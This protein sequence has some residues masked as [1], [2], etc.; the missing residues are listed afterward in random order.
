MRCRSVNHR[1]GPGAAGIERRCA[2][3]CRTSRAATRE[4]SPYA[5][6]GTRLLAEPRQQRG[7]A[8]RLGQRRAE[9][10]EVFRAKQQRA[11]AEAAAL[12]VVAEAQRL[13]AVLVDE[14]LDRRLPAMLAGAGREAG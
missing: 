6:P 2:P 4:P 7:D 5:L 13:G 1:D 12:V 9:R 3:G 11:A 8:G 10:G 14:E